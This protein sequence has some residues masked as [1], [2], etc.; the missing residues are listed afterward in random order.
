MAKLY[1][2]LL[3]TQFSL[4]VPVFILLMFI[5]APYGKFTKSG[6]GPSLNARPG[7]FLMELPAVILPPIFYLLSG[8]VADFP[9][10]LF[11]L[12]WELHYIQRTFVYPALLNRGSHTMP[13]L[14]ILFSMLFKP[15][16]RVHK[17]FRCFHYGA[18]LS[19]VKPPYRSRPG[20]LCGGLCNKHAFG[21]DPPKP[22][23]TGRNR[24]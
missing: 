5:R 14:I 12:V 23:G 17:R 13:L 6:W 11:I 18:G 22:P 9:G 16:K 24:L 1:S 2:I 19:G 7:W 20:D 4:A 21:Q 10:I 8:R 3:I 15:D